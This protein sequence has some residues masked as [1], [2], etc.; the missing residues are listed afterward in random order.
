[1]E[2]YETILPPNFCDQLKKKFQSIDKRWGHLA[3]YVDW[4][5]VP[6]IEDISSEKPNDSEE[7]VIKPKIKLKVKVIT[8]IEKTEE[9]DEDPNDLDHFN[10]CV[11]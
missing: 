7:K 4:S 9:T 2:I 5:H 11:L 1:M 3:T 10:Q 6:T 8:K